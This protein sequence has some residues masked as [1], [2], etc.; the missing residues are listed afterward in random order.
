[1][2]T[3]PPELRQALDE[4]P[5]A[6][7]RLVD[8]RTNTEYVLLNAAVYERVR[9]LFE[10]VPLTV[11]EQVALL[12]AAGDRAGWDDPEMDV[13]DNFRGSR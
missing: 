3:L 9:A 12:R 4:H 13:Y 5:D 7:V 8:E 6:P 1:M 10:E 11:P 2:P